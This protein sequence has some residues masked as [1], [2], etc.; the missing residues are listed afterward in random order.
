MGEVT[1]NLDTN[2]KQK[3]AELKEGAMAMR[4]VTTEAQ[5]ADRQIDKNIK[6]GRKQS[7]VNKFLAKERKAEAAALK[8]SARETAAATR[9]TERDAKAKVRSARASSRL[10][11]REAALMSRIRGRQSALRKQQRAGSLR[12]RAGAFGKQAYSGGRGIVA[13]AAAVAVAGRLINNSFSEST[14]AA[15]ELN[16]AM[17]PLVALGENAK[18]YKEVTAEINNMRTVFGV[19][20]DQASQLKFNIQSGGAALDK[21]T[22][23]GIRNMTLLGNQV[24]GWDID[25]TS[26]LGTKTF[27]IYGKAV[28]S[29]SDVFNKF[30]V[31]GS[32]A[33]ATMNEMA[34]QMPELMAAAKGVGVGFD[35]VL[36]SVITLTPSAGKASVAINQLRN[37]F[38]ILKK[39][40]LDG[41]ITATIYKDQLKEFGKLPIGTQMQLMGRETLAASVVMTASTDKVT[42]SMEK[43]KSATGNS[44]VEMKKLREDASEA[45]RITQQMKRFTEEKKIARGSDEAVSVGSEFDERMDQFAAGFVGSL[46]KAGA[47]LANITHYTGAGLVSDSFSELGETLSSQ[48][49]NEFIQANLSRMNANQLHSERMQQQTSI[50]LN[51]SGGKTHKKNKENI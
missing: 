1:F 38:M 43:L 23:D 12:G 33:D 48:G 5:K 47:V 32:D 6:A 46:M 44:L 42:A 29:V 27:N 3:T 41:I 40:Q 10:A 35:E 25:A 14:A 4:K 24:A 20:A 11:D 16:D 13:G 45:F 7:T 30:V 15:M 19:T 2:I 17:T 28:G 37:M 34:I 31:T 26:K 51:K 21:M 9:A 8:R 36:A 50:Q 39:A 49:E 22:Q 18:N